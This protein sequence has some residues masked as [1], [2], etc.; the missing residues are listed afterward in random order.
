MIWLIGMKTMTNAE[1]LE[2]AVLHKYCDRLQAEVERLRWENR[3]YA[4]MIRET[5]QILGV[6]LGYLPYPADWE[7]D[8]V[9]IGEHTVVTL[10]M[11]AAERLR[12]VSYK[13]LKGR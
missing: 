6:A 4:Q 5:E 10:A 7:T 9:C 13:G 1:I 12:E 8:A 3:K 2:M 11:E